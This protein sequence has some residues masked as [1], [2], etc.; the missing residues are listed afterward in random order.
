LLCEK[1]REDE[2]KGGVDTKDQK[3]VRWRTH[4]HQGR[5]WNPGEDDSDD[6]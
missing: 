6:D 2:E 3:A 4:V 5:D 1:W